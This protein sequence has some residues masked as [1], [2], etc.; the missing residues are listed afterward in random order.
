MKTKLFRS[1]LED[2]ISEL[3]EGTILNYGKKYSMLTISSYKQVY[4]C[5]VTLKFDFD[6]NKSDLNN[7]KKSLI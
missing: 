6:V 4:N 2:V 7:V 3:E 1:L 5:M